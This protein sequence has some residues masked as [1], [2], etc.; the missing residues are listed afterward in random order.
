MLKT[1]KARD[2]HSQRD[3]HSFLHSFVNGNANDR[4]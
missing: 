2:C 3:V 4:A 1:G